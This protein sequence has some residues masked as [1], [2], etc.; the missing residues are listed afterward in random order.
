MSES[1]HTKGELKAIVANTENVLVARIRDASGHDIANVIP[2][3]IDTA[4]RN[5]FVANAERLC[6]CW[7][8]HDASLAALYKY[9]SHADGCKFNS[10]GSCDCGLKEA[11]TAA[12]G[13]P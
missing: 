10:P 13:K 7:N 5:E 4:S 11:I 2:R 6:F 9:G 1:K 3:G 12:A 8:S